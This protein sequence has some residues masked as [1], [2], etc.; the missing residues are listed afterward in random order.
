MKK[1]SI[2]L[3]LL[4]LLL[5][6]SCLA[7]GSM[8]PKE[9]AQSCLTEVYG[10]TPEEAEAFVFEDDGKGTLT[11]YPKGHPAWAYQLIYADD[12]VIDGTTPF[13]TAY[14][15][16]PGESAVRDTL[17]AMKEQNIPATWAQG[18][19]KAMRDTLERNG[20]VPSQ[21]LRAMLSGQ[22]DSF[23]GNKLIE[24]FFVSCFGDEPTWPE[25]LREWR[26]ETLTAFGFD[27]PLTW[28]EQPD[29]IE[30]VPNVQTS[31]GTATLI[32]FKGA[33]PDNLKAVLDAQPRLKGWQCLTGAVLDGQAQTDDALS[34]LPEWHGVGLAAF[35]QGNERLLVSLR[36]DES[37]L[38]RL[39][40]LGTNALYGP[41]QR[42]TIDYG[43]RANMFNIRYDHA[44]ETTVFDVVLNT[45]TLNEQP[46]GEHCYIQRIVF[47]G[48]DRTTTV[49]HDGNGRWNVTEV[50]DGRRTDKTFIPSAPMMLGVEDILAFPRSLEDIISPSASHIPEGYTVVENVHLRQ[51][52]SSRSKDLGMLCRGA[53]VRMLG[54][55]PGQPYEWVHAKAG[56]LTGYISS[57]YTSAGA[58]GTN[59]PSY[60]S[61]LLLAETTKETDLKKDTGWFSGRVQRLPKGTRMH[62][63]MERGSFLYVVI[64]RNQ[65][66]WRM[67]V[68]GTYGF[69]P[70]DA[71]LIAPLPVQLDWLSDK[72][73]S[74][75]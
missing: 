49:T 50:R 73:P 7:E 33:V 34:L 39:F 31:M 20:I 69:I 46:V 12:R 71:V 66:H 59:K 55:E 17:R 45:Q 11:Y 27:R 1:P 8:T 72:A 75:P 41:P 2:F 74:N 5:A 35:E 26:N 18:G 6:F 4:C 68:D 61:P 65:L 44:G 51:K 25:A 22:A 28:A 42:L 58:N 32:R 47:S 38:W 56:D 43:N 57:I 36:K 30:T 19:Q 67:D 16:Y 62:V 53:F 10:Y 13:H 40:S 52:T 23:E 3:A 54:M 29:G 37:G 21:A 15:H 60:L 9:Q 70:R 48:S 64:P 63:M 14:I 24:T